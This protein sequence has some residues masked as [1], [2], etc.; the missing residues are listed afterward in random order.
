MAAVDRWI[1]RVVVAVWRI[2]SDGEERLAPNTHAE[3]SQ[4]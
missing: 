2:T 3:E 4:L 1:R